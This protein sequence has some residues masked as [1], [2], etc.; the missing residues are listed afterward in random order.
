M[1]ETAAIEHLSDAV[2]FINKVREEGCLFALDDFG[3]GMSSFTYLKT[4]PADFIKID[5]TFVASM[6]SEPMDSAIVEAINHIGHLAGKRTIAEFVESSATM[7]QLRDINVDF[8]Q[9]FAIG[10]PGPIHVAVE[11]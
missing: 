4:I 1:T 7:K 10:M 11:A 9:G 6:E 8:V 5:G 2:E 3:S